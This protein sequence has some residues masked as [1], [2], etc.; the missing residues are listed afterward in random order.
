MSMIGCQFPHWRDT[1]VCQISVPGATLPSQFP[2]GR[3]P[4]PP[5]KKQ[6]IGALNDISAREA[7]DRQT[8]NRKE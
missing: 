3:P 7:L 4:S 1:T 2:G 5:S 8:G 6:L